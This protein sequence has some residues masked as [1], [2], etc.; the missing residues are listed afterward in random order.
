[1]RKLLILSLLALSSGAYAKTIKWYKGTVVL[2]DERVLVGD[3]SLEP[4]HDLILIRTGNAVKVYTAYKIKSFN[5]YDVEQHIN[6]KFLTLKDEETAKIPSHIY[7]VVLRG[8][9]TILRQ[10]KSGFEQEN[11]SSPLKNFNYY[12]RLDNHLVNIAQFRRAVFPVLLQSHTD[13]IITFIY[14]HNLNPNIQD[15]AI[16]IIEFYNSQEN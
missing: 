15:N 5:F 13:Q 16:K 9:A 14:Q 2:S 6:R 3:I 1:M 8:K 4:A 7:E 10:P 12:V 11:N